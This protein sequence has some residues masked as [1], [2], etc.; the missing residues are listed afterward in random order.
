MP[1]DPARLQLLGTLIDERLKLSE[2]ETFTDS[3]YLP[4]F[5]ARAR[6]QIRA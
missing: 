1:I 3:P 5:M 4:T 6:K 2:Q